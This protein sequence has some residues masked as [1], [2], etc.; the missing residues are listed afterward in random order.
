[1]SKLEQAFAAMREKIA[2]EAAMTGFR[3]CNQAGRK[4]PHRLVP[5]I[6]VLVAAALASGQ[7]SAAPGQPQ[8]TAGQQAP[9]PG[10]SR[11]GAGATPLA[12]PAAARAPESA[13]A[14][15]RRQIAD[16]AARLVTLATALKAEVDKTDKDTLSLTVIRKADEIEKLART[17]KEKMKLSLGTN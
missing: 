5:A 16:D 2:R 9:D 15:R 10:P 3:P 7:Q 4:I 14:E 12:V 1:M 13:N 11:P 6:L 8:P 17:V